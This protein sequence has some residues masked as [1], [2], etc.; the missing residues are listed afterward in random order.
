[1]WTG[2]TI[3]VIDIG[4][5]APVEN[6][7]AEVQQMIRSVKNTQLMEGSTGVLFPG[8]IEAN[9]RNDRLANGIPVDQT[10]W[11]QVEELFDHYGVR[12]QLVDVVAPG[13]NP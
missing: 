5:M 3:L 2:S 9:S 7:Q 11:G 4:H 13:S 10:T 8:E 12:E 6:I 1:M